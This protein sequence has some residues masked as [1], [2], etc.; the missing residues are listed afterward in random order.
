VRSSFI[1]PLLRALRWDTES[2]TEVAVEERLLE[3][4]C[5]YTL[6]IPGDRRPRVFI[7]AK[8]FELGPKGLDGHT[9][10]GGRPLSFPQQ[11]IRYA[12]QSQ[13]EWAVLTN[14]K[15]TRL[16][17]AYIDPNDPDSGL[18][19]TVPIEDFEAHFDELWTL[20]KESVRTGGLDALPKKRA[21]E[22]I[23]VAAPTDLFAC[24]NRLASD[25]HRHDPALSTGDVQQAAQRI[26]DRL[27]VMRAAEDRQVLPA[28]TLSTLHQAWKKALIDPSSLFI[29]SL[30]HQ[31]EQFDNVYNSEMFAPNHV[32]DRVSIGNGTMDEVLQVLY[33]YNF[34]LID[35]DILGSIYEGYLSFVLGEEK[36]ELTFEREEG[37]RKRHGVYYTPT[38]VVEYLV[39]H[40]LGPLLEDA[41][42]SRLA[43]LRL[44]DPACGSG[45]FLIKSYD[46]VAERYS[47]LNDEAKA[48]AKGRRTIE[49]HE[50]R[51]KEVSG[52]RERILREN[53]YGV[54]L[55]GQAAEIAAINLMLKA[56]S[57][58]QRLP[59]ILRENV[60]VGNAL[61]SG[62]DEDLR[63]V[64]GEEW[65]KKE[66]FR[67][68]SEF[69]SILGEGVGGFD[70]VVGN[71]PYVDSKAIA[72][73]EREYFHSTKGG[74]PLPFPTAYKK[75]DL[76]A[77]FLELGVRLLRPG[78]RLAFIVPD[79]VLT[80]PYASKLRP[81]I[82]D[83]CAVE[84][85]IDLTATRVFPHQTVKNVIVV[86]RKEPDSTARE[87]NVVRVG[88]V[89]K[90]TDLAGGIPEPVEQ[91]Q[92]SVFRT[93][94]DFQ[95]RL[96]FRD[97][98]LLEIALKFERGTT[99]LEDIFYVNWG[100]RTGTKEKTRTLISMDSTAA[101]AKPLLR[102][103]DI[104]G[105]YVMDWGGQY[106]RYD[107]EKLVNPLFPEALGSPKI[108]V[109]KIS[110]SRGL[111]A[112]FDDKGLYPFSTVILA[113]PYHYVAGV[114]R[115][116]VPEETVE[117]SRKYDPKY[118][119]AVIN[120]RA[121]RFYYDMMIADGLSVVPSHLNRLP[122]PDASAEVQTRL[123]ALAERLLEL[124][125]ELQEEERVGSFR[126][127][128]SSRPRTGEDGLG[129][130][131]KDLGEAGLDVRDR[132]DEVTKASR[133]SV[134]PELRPESLELRVRYRPRGSEDEEQGTV[135]CRLDP[136]VAAYLAM[137]LR[138]RKDLDLGSGRPM[139]KVRGIQVPRFDADWSRHMEVVRAVVATVQE[140]E[141]RA[142]K[143]SVQIE[144][145]E[146]EV[147]RVVYSLFGLGADD[148]ARIQAFRPRD[149]G[150][151]G[152]EPGPD[153][154][155][156]N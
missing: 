145:T 98:A 132:L 129:D 146:A 107:P 91:V 41:D 153:E 36:G 95:F 101:N 138:D 108:V 29:K 20:S 140:H 114:A 76:Y 147:D 4:H 127:V 31:F 66:P 72:E 49:E 15:E 99:R 57:R 150:P 43:A 86:L 135:V 126:R 79:K 71:P 14:F 89:P 81:F 139:T 85:I 142:R 80:A 136:T 34:D 92:Q 144:A 62:G 112:T 97:R 12:W 1:D 56:L 94:N 83:T 143:F 61:I 27:I 37:T 84:Q 24:R 45:S 11:A 25:I 17:S 73:P 109:R 8:R 105:R 65:R 119:L 63:T 82:L 128:A 88:I 69:P 87:V 64:F 44:V 54:D 16:Y 133:I 110:G 111:F 152:D 13:A 5:D 116:Q 125:R 32:C 18:V 90:G 2:R 124:H 130:Y 38:Y 134:W 149:T 106:I 70:V 77:L 151:G 154:Q 26:L 21:R 23:H 123:A 68:A 52:F 3:G 75:S 113:L 121:I 115:A 7:E 118:V 53:L 48:S 35:A 55:D 104:A 58:G 74:R 59:L 103:E 156:E 155:A 22:T 47:R 42:R 102:G 30:R 131:L 117:R 93:L 33:N 6:R 40:A 100:L 51:P 19:F 141:V 9:E 137:V 120:S 46:R 122:I 148:I 39:D 10:R 67:W 28:E 78:G 96:E 60:R 50:D